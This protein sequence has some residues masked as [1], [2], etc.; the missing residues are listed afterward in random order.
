[1][2]SVGTLKTEFPSARSLHQWLHVQLPEKQ[3]AFA[4]YDSRKRSQ[5][6]AECV[7]SADEAR[8]LKDWLSRLL[9]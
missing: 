4:I 3:F 2:R 9:G 7:I 5:S 1:M 8:R 6:L